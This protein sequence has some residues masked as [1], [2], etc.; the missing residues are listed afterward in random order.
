MEPWAELTYCQAELV[1]S[2]RHN[3]Q[4]FCPNGTTTYLSDHYSQGALDGMAECVRVPL[5]NYSSGWWV[6]A[7]CEY[8]EY[9]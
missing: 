3:T 9:T 6:K 7:W 4:T 8:V 5:A 1:N 2:V